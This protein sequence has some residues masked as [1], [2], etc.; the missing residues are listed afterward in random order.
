[1]YKRNSGL[2]DREIL[3]NQFTAYVKRAVH[4][5]RI[6]FLRDESRSELAETSLTVIET[7]TRDPK[8]M[9]AAFLEQEALRRALLEIRDKER[10]VI[11]ARV[12]D[13][14][15]VEEIATELSLSYR[16]VTSI[17]YRC[18]QKLRQ[19]LEGGGVE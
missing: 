13:G 16:A 14:K 2:E 17:L 12:L 3:Q 9:I 5:R 8:D 4:N 15:S 10:Y 19:L 7:Y 11:L 1:M 6:R 18:K